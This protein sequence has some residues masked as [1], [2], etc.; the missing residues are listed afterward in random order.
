MDGV[1]AQI[2]TQLP[3]G[4]LNRTLIQAYKRV[5]PPY[6][7]G[8]RL[9]IFYATQ[10]SIKPITILLFVNDSTKLISAYEAYLIGALRKTFGLEGA[11]VIF[12]LKQRTHHDQSNYSKAV[13]S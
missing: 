6:V 13:S 1:A 8:K 4:V 3:T 11:P 9:K 10:V 12:K 2:S 5:A 7:K